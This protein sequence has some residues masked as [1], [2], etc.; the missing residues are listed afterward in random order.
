MFKRTLT[1]LSL[2][3]LTAFTPLKAEDKGTYFVGSVGM[4]QMADIDIATSLGGGQFEFDPG[5]SGEIGIGYDFGSLRTEFTYNAT[6]TDLTTVQGTSTDIGVDISTWMVSAA[7]DW[8]ADKKWQPY[9]SAGLGA[10]TIEVNL[11]QTVGSVAVIV[12]DD[13]ITAFKLK[14][15]VNYE[16]SENLDVYG[17]VWGQAFDDFTIGTLQFKD[18]GMAG[19]SLGLRFK[20]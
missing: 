17:E 11:A 14:A 10:S 15:G 6:N 5:F 7:Y 4:G 12:D 9:I 20:L 3:S 13:N 16:A 8:R 2:L 18:C 1:S 19:L